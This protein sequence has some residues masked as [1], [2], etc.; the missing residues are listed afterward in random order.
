MSFEML[1]KIAFICLYVY[2]CYKEV[3][4]AIHAYKQKE[5]NKQIKTNR[6]N[7]NIDVN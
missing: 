5:A 4:E 3:K 1:I 2:A 6:A 7:T